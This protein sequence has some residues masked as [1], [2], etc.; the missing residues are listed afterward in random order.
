MATGS[1]RV[2]PCPCGTRLMPVVQGATSDMLTPARS[3]K[4][5]QTSMLLTGSV[6]SPGSICGALIISGTR[7]DPS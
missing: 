7:D 3:H 2:V 1:V 4:V 6:T 5:G